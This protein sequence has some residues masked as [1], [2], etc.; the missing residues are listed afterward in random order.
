MYERTIS[1]AT[2]NQR[3]GDEARHKQQFL[4]DIKTVCQ[5]IG[6]SEI[7][8]RIPKSQYKLLHRCHIH[9]PRIVAAQDADMTKQQLHEER[10]YL[11]SLLKYST[12][13][14]V[15]G[16]PELP[17]Q[18]ALTAGWTLAFY[19]RVLDEHMFHGAAALKQYLSLFGD[20]ATFDERMLLPLFQLLDIHC[21]LNCDMGSRI[22]WVE[23]RI[24]KPG[25]V[26]DGIRSTLVLH[27]RKPQWKSL[28][29]DNIRRPVVRV[30]WAYSGVGWHTLS[31]NAA[32]LT[33]NEADEGRSLDVYIQTHALRRMKERLDSL[34][35]G[36]AQYFLTQAL[37]DVRASTTPSGSKLIE[38]RI[39]D[40]KAGYLVADIVED[41]VVIRT[42]LF[43][44]NDGTPEGKKL[45]ITCGLGRLDKTFLAF[46]KLSSFAAADIGAN[47]YL[48]AIFVEAGCGSLL[49][50]YPPLHAINQNENLFSP[51]EMW[52]KYLGLKSRTLPQGSVA[53]NK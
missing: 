45:A 15:S 7:F 46:E 16:A 19:L 49:D 24:E 1:R 39:Q 37:E 34:P 2:R 8:S 4:E 52:V 5:A 21:F 47:P 17:M 41:C 32:Q 36:L 31:V 12:M 48:R 22:T 51:I 27:A 13:P 25:A 38:F 11:P 30:S 10:Q 53:A 23:H 35:F 43:L 44:T 26:V 42:F 3:Q 29:L 40:K 28:V 9:L 33:G 14:F 18:L 20:T 50:L 6:H